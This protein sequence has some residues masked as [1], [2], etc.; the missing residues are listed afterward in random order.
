MYGCAAQC[1]YEPTLLPCIKK[2]ITYICFMYVV[3]MYLCA[4]LRM[5]FD[6][7]NETAMLF[8]FFLSVL[9]RVGARCADGG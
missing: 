8:L 6:Q 5:H 9:G 7:E 2:F 3:C 1:M 4:Y